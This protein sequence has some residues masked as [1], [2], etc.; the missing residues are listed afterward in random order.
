MRDFFASAA[1]KLRAAADSAAADSI[2]PKR[3]EPAAVTAAAA[4]DMHS[5]LTHGRNAPA[6]DPSPADS[7]KAERTLS[8]LRD[9]ARQLGIRSFAAAAAAAAAAA[10]GGRAGGRGKEGGAAPPDLAGLVGELRRAEA[11]WS[12]ADCAGTARAIV[13]AVSATA[14]AGGGFRPLSAGLR[15]HREPAGRA[16]RAS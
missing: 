7:V 1:T 10:G 15:F 9:A 4:A 3:T 8:N 13:A 6:G 12:A 5:A 11:A 16:R 2:A 14:Q